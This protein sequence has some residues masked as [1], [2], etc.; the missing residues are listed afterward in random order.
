MVGVESKYGAHAFPAA[1]TD[2]LPIV[3]L[4]PD[5]DKFTRAM[6]AAARYSTGAITTRSMLHGRRRRIRIMRVPHGRT[7]TRWTSAYAV[8]MSIWG[9]LDVEMTESDRALIIG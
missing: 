4:K 5:A 1:C 7:T 9:Y 3:E 8:L 2:G 6:P